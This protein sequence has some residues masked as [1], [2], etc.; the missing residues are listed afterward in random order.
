MSEQERTLADIDA[1]LALLR[2]RARALLVERTH[3]IERMEDAR[4]R[5]LQKLLQSLLC[6]HPSRTR[7]V[8][9]GG[10]AFW[11]CDGCE[12]VVERAESETE[13]DEEPPP[14]PEPVAP[15]NGEDAP[16]GIERI[17][18]VALFAL[19]EYSFSLPT[20]TTIGKR[21]RALRGARWWIGEY[22]PCEKPGHVGIVWKLAELVEE[23]PGFALETTPGGGAYPVGP[24]DF[25]PRPIPPEP[26]PL[27]PF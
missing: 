2:Q 3:A 5:D 22:V 12:Q 14:A 13:P 19:P 16:N 1:E 21:W 24:P 9:C 17:D 8:G 4:Q 11:I 10:R 6:P 20:G 7:F 18:K 15:P 27:E 23:P 26:P 25:T